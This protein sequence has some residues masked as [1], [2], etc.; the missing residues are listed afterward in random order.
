MAR[1]SSFELIIELC[2][3]RWCFGFGG[4]NGP[5]VRN[6]WHFDYNA[7]RRPGSRHGNAYALSRRPCGPDESTYCE[8]VEARQHVPDDPFCGAVTKV[9]HFLSILWCIY[10]GLTT[11]T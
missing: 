1:S 8:R 4:L 7:V 9:S 3:G 11:E 5:L 10:R 2:D 6:S